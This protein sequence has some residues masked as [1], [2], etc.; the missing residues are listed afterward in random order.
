MA[1]ITGPVAR[2]R[3]AI[4]VRR[5]PTAWGTATQEDIETRFAQITDDHQ[6]DPR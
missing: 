1:M 4:G 3:A 6:W 5:R 2:L